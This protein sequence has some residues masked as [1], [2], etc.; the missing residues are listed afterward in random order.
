MSARNWF[1]VLGAAL[2]LSA[3][4]CKPSAEEKKPEWLK[5]PASYQPATN[6]KLTFNKAGLEKYNFMDQKDRDAFATQL[7]QAANSFEGQA[8]VQAGTGVSAHVP[9]HKYG[10][11]EITARA[12]KV[13]YEISINYA[14]YTTPE[15]GR[16]IARNRA[17]QFRGTVIG[18]EYQGNNKP[19]ELTVRV[20][21]SE[22]KALE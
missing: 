4:A 2:T 7:S 14:L 17:V 12:E 5:P 9:E 6:P 8:I 21:V 11:W 13:L 16:K 20:K 22:I 19:R 1:L 10:T 3:S 15:L 18:L